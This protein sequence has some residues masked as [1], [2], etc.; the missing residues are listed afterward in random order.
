[1][2]TVQATLLEHLPWEELRFVTTFEKQG[3]HEEILKDR[4][5]TVICHVPVLEKLYLKTF[6]RRTIHWTHKEPRNQ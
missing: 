1:M 5:I 3:T 2:L 6:L 4:Y